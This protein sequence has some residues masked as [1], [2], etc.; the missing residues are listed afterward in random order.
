MDA[1]FSGDA[2]LA[3]CYFYV[4]L[5]P[6]NNRSIESYQKLIEDR[7]M[8]EIETI[9]GVAGLSLNAGAPTELQIQV[10]PFKAA[11]LGVGLGEIAR[12]AGGAN[13]V[14]GGFVDLG[15]RQYLLRFAGRYSPQEL[16]RLV[17]AWR[18]DKPVYLG[19]IAQVSVERGKRRSFTYQNGKPALSFRV[20]RESGANVLAVLDAVKTVVENQ[21][22][23]VLADND[24]DIAISFDPSVFINRAVNLVG[25]NLLLGILLTIAVLWWF[26]RR[27]AATLI[28]ATA[29]PIS[30]LATFVFLGFFGRSI[31]VISLAG[32]AF[33]VGMVVDAAIV[34][35]ENILRLRAQSPGTQSVTHAAR[36]A[37]RQVWGALLASTATTVAIFL[38]VIFL[39]DVEGQLFADL[40]LTIAI[41]VICSLI[42]AVAVLPVAAQRFLQSNPALGDEPDDFSLPNTIS[43]DRIANKIMLIT[44]K[45]WR[46]YVLVLVLMG[47]PIVFTPLL[48]PKMDYLPPVKRDALQVFF[49]MPPGANLEFVEEEIVGPVIERLQPYL[50]GEKQPALKNYYVL[51][52]GPF[53]A[54]MGIRPQDQS[55]VF[56][57]LD[58]LRREILTDLP[59]ASTFAMQANLFGNF[60]TGGEVLMLIQSR[61]DAARIALGR[62]AL[63]LV[64]EYLPAAQARPD[65][66]LDQSDPELRLIPNDQAIA[67]AGL[68]RISLA[69]I[70]RAFGNGLY[71]GEYYDGDERMD[72]ILDAGHWVTPEDLAAAPVATPSGRVFQLGQLVD[73][74]ETVGT[75]TVN[76]VSGTRTQLLMITPPQRVSLEETIEI[77]REHVEPQ[78][79]DLMP[80]DA[81]ILYSGS[82]SSLQESVNKMLQ[83]FALALGIL[84]I[85]LAGLF[86][87]LKDSLMVILT[88]PLATI[89]GVLALR[90]LN[91][92]YFQPMDLLTM[93]GF[94]ILLGLVVN[95]AILLVYQTRSAQNGGLSRRLAVREALGVRVRPIMMSTLTSIFG[96]LP[97]L[98]IPGEGSVIYRGL[99]GVIIGGMLVST[100]FTLVLL[101]CLLRIGEGNAQ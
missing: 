4:Q 80:E 68:S 65:P 31:N 90:G 99:A 42:V 81:S 6:G 5:K 15:R 59:D 3:L 97:L 101:P 2:N 84:F 83:N 17:L 70:V 87:S 78:L 13:D 16:E 62:R 73:V 21:R 36:E 28:I 82:A 96:M 1:V 56:A 43:F 52:F 93:I 88:I 29:I 46:R 79:Q 77:L 67:E 71:I 27:V 51:S 95:N 11:E 38:P 47:I 44:D 12:I 33:A 30:L 94:I 63:A 40:A 74:V 49:N 22:L 37:P 86:R 75:S 20:D 45:P 89:G 57:L 48:M 14:S 35:L 92:I 55:E 50:D 61:D 19:D 41:A 39:K 23:G 7:V 85:L 53:G 25:G 72:V 58:V 98:V 10:D 34:V 66:P 76:H 54:S 69:A 100:L 8:A 18:N 32:L 64:N 9:P 91:L 60:T 24:L 26:L